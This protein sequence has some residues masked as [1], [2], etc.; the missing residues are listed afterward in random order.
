MYFAD[1][2]V[3]LLA[4]RPGIREFLNA[5]QRAFAVYRW[6]GRTQFI[7]VLAGARQS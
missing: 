7:R 3:V 6:D 5:D 4:T 1:A 2:S